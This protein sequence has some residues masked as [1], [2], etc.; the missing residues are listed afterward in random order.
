[1]AEPSSPGGTMKRVAGLREM[2]DLH[3]LRRTDNEML[4]IGRSDD[5]SGF[6]TALGSGHAF[7]VR[8]AALFPGL[9]P[10]LPEVQQRAPGHVANGWHR[11]DLQ[12]ALTAVL[13][14]S[15]GV[16]AA[17]PCETLAGPRVATET[18][19]AGATKACGAGA[20][21]L[22][23]HL[24]ACPYTEADSAVDVARA[25]K[26]KL[27]KE[28]AGHLLRGARRCVLKGV[29]GKKRKVLK[30]GCPKGKAW[31]MRK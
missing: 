18:D 1:M 25:L 16:Q 8:I 3:L 23:K 11:A 20:S 19:R 21:E 22:E 2:A 13:A 14:A 15:T 4:H 31:R 9:G 28:A 26:E 6:A 12:E 17:P 7:E 29:D 27:G 10:R 5:T 30:E 24:E